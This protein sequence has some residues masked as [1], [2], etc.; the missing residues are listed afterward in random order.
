MDLRDEQQASGGEGTKSGLASKRRTRDRLLFPIAVPLATLGMIA[1]L[2][3][4]FSRIL[5]G[6]S[7]A[8]APFVTLVVAT[9]VLAGAAYVASRP[10][11][12][13]VDLASLLGVVTGVAMV[14][15]GLGIVGAG[16]GGPTKK[17]PYRHR[18]SPS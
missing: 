6:M 12:R 1:L 17:A 4:S 18:W 14:A 7:K 2:S 11:V 8:A 10:R 5:L 15:G 9:T 16:G 13:A 3:F